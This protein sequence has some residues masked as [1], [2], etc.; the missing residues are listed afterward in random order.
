[1]KN[2]PNTVVNAESASQRGRGR[3]IVPFVILAILG[4]A[5][6]VLCL[7]GRERAGE[8]ARGPK[9]VHSTPGAA[10]GSGTAVDGAMTASTSNAALSPASPAANQTNENAVPSPLDERR[11]VAATQ[12][13]STASAATAQRHSAVFGR[14]HRP[15]GTG[16]AG[17]RVEVRQL[18]FD[19][20][21]ITRAVDQTAVAGDVTDDGGGYA[22]RSLAAGGYL[23]YPNLPL[24]HECVAPKPHALV[25]GE[26][27]NTTGCDFVLQPGD[28]IYGWVVDQDKQPVPVALLRARYEELRLGD[29]TTRTD[30][31]GFYAIGGI[32]PGAAIASLHASKEGYSQAE[33][34]ELASYHGPQNFVLVKGLGFVLVTIDAASGA[35]VTHYE[36]QVLNTTWHGRGVEPQHANVRVHAPEGR[37]LITGLFNYGEIDIRVREIDTAG[38]RTERIGATHVRIDPAHDGEQ[39]VVVTIGEGGAIRGTVVYEGGQ[40]ASGIGVQID[41]LRTLGA[42]LVRGQV[43]ESTVTDTQGAFVLPHAFPGNHQL[44]VDADGFT[45]KDPVFVTV[46]EEGDAPPVCVVLVGGGLV[47]G[48]I[49]GMDGAPVAGL[50]IHY[51][52]YVEWYKPGRSCT[53]DATGLYEFSGISPG[54]HRVFFESSDGQ[55][56]GDEFFQLQG[57]EEKELNFDFSTDILLTGY[58]VSNGELWNG[59]PSL[60]LRGVD[61]IQPFRAIRRTGPG[62]YELRIAP[63]IYDLVAGSFRYNIHGDAIYANSAP[64]GIIERIQIDEQPREQTLDL[65]VVF[66]DGAYL[67]EAPEDEAFRNGVLKFSQRFNGMEFRDISKLDITKMGDPLRHLVPGLYKVE[68][69]SR[70]GGWK[71]ESEWTTVAVGGE[72]LFHIRLD[73]GTPVKIGGWKTEMLSELFAPLDCDASSVVDGVGDYVVALFYDSGACMLMIEWVSLLEDGRE[74]ARDTH[75]GMTGGKQ[76]DNV[77]RFRNVRCLSGARYTVRYSGRLSGNGDSFGSV[78]L[79]RRAVEAE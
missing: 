59:T 49:T 29:A 52:E 74:V 48:R 58:V 67:I 54:H 51:A 65:D 79:S 71:G 37:K 60:A 24:G 11:A 3:W 7:R 33:K 36:Y 12:A 2:N 34:T 78:Y 43:I 40:P 4:L 15:D 22:I 26:G 44:L 28:M 20:A 76:Y 73:D 77:Y 23:V 62:A 45:P 72:N 64:G 38:K 47:Y 69:W 25:L 70:D 6:A 17:I 31:R 63:G 39:E 9:G 61:G 14:V 42:G 18:S 35:P 46:P 57:G 1:V 5:A 75:P 19:P 32:A 10:D 66:A 27:Q 30:E 16:V 41:P 21:S 50:S 8:S 56:A 13:V 68:Y 53:T 55:I